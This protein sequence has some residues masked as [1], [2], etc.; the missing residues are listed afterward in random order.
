MNSVVKLGAQPAKLGLTAAD[1]HNTETTNSLMGI[2]IKAGEVIIVGGKSDGEHITDGIVEANQQVIIYPAATLK[3]IK[4]Q[5]FVSINP[6]L[7]LH[8]MCSHATI[9]E[10][11]RGE[12][13]YIAFKAGRR[14]DL[15][16]LQYLICVYMID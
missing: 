10:P 2:R 12:D 7:L 15:K 14:T 5:T 8:G 9:I 13:I 11:G 6:E 4:Y 1:K 3:P 16:S